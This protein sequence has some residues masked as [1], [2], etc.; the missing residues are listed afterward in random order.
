GKP[1][2]TD[3]ISFHPEQIT[4]GN[5]SDNT[6]SPTYTHFIMGGNTEENLPEE[7]KELLYW[8]GIAEMGSEHPLSTPLVEEAQKYYARLPQPDHFEAFPG[9][10][11]QAEYKTDTIRVGTVDLMEQAG[12]EVRP[13]VQ[14]KITELAREGRTVVLAALNDILLGALGISD[15]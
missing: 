13:E 14:N 12:I 4:A 9:F 2:L 11:I 15:P 7:A 3:V 8:T 10:G 5:M 6:T 1:R